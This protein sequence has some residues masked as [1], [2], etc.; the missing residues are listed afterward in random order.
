MKRSDA[1]FVHRAGVL[2]LMAIAMGVGVAA[3]KES[4]QVSSLIEPSFFRS[5]SLLFG[6]LAALAVSSYSLAYR[7][8]SSARLRSEIGILF[9][10]YTLFLGVA[11]PS[12]LLRQVQSGD[13]C[14]VWE[15][16]CSN[17]VWVRSN[18]LTFPFFLIGSVILLRSIILV[19]RGD[20][21]KL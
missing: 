5:L 21:Q 19:L 10:S 17:E 20:Q 14:R 4:G 18:W 2:S 16:W 13:Q 15:V 8:L 1:K 9:G 3:V 7:S 6:P 11:A 12:F